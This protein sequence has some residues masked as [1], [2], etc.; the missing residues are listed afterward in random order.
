MFELNKGNTIGTASDEYKKI[1]ANLIE[2]LS[3]HYVKVIEEVKYEGSLWVRRNGSGGYLFSTQS[4]FQIANKRITEEL[5]ALIARIQKENAVTNNQL[6]TGSGFS[7]TFYTLTPAKIEN[8]LAYLLPTITWFNKAYSHLDILPDTIKPEHLTQSPN[9]LTTTLIEYLGKTKLERLLKGQNPRERNTILAGMR[10]KINALI[11]EV[12]KDRPAG[13]ELPEIDLSRTDGLQITVTSSDKFSFYK[14]KLKKDF[15]IPDESIYEVAVPKTQFPEA[16]GSGIEDGF[17][18]ADFAKLLAHTGNTP[19]AE[20][21]A[22]SNSEYM[23]RKE[24]SKVPKRV[25]AH[26]FN[27]CITS[28]NKDDFEEETLS[29]MCRILDF[30]MNDDWFS[31]W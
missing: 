18:K 1:T 19:E 23:K 22:L 29:N 11:N 31:M 25:V 4:S 8:L 14:N 17:S 13:A 7:Y 30:C 15:G 6:R 21:E 9:S 24:I 27:K 12:N 3:G 16:K 5:P 20:F 28:F 2:N 10:G 26:E